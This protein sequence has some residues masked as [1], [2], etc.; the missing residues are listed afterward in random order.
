MDIIVCNRGY[1]P[2]SCS[3]VRPGRT[4]RIVHTTEQATRPLQAAA[5]EALVQNWRALLLAALV[6]TLYLP[7]LTRLA[8]QWYEDPDYSH[9][10]LVPVFSAYVLWTRRAELGRLIPRPSRWGMMLLLPSLALLFLGSLGAEL[11]LTR[12]SLWLTIVALV[13]HFQGWEWMRKAIFPLGFLLLMIP[14]PTIIYNQI[15][16][17][18]QLLASQFAT[19]CL[20][21][22]GIVPVLREGNLLIL[23]N[24]TIEVVEAC[25]GIRSLLSLIAL[26]LAYGYLVEKSV[27][28]RSLLVAAMVPLAILSNG[29][30]VLGTALMTHYWGPQ[31]A[32]GFFHNFSGMVI[33]VVS[34]MLLLAVHSGISAIRSRVKERTS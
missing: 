19:T 17:P 3:E 23:P 16:F 24:Y 31:A 27:P 2:R 30:R 14:P 9:G 1:I 8:L 6:V 29:T 21:V 26:A 20:H 10:F 18:L 5:W 15:V 33:F 11:F 28:V 34:T 25:S 4:Q 7:V 32:E 13:L 12:I 22:S